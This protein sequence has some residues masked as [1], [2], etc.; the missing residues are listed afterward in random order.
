MAN[1][2]HGTSGTYCVGDPGSLLGF[3]VPVRSYQDWYR[4]V[5]M[6]SHHNCTVMHDW[7][8]KPLA[9]CP[10]IPLSHTTLIL[11]KLT[12]VLS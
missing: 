9:L 6:G 12:I 5:H 7:K 10:D 2:E 3:Y 1:I 11:S 8:T 4:L